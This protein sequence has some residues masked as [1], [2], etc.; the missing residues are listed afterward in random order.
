M[1][2][3]FPFAD[4]KKK[5]PAGPKESLER[6]L[7]IVMRLFDFGYVDYAAFSDRF[8]ANRRT[9][10]RDLK[11]IRSASHERLSVSQIKNGRAV[12]QGAAPRL[13]PLPTGRAR[14]KTAAL[15]RIAAELGGPLSDELRED[16]ARADD[17]FLDVREPKPAAPDCI[18]EVFA[19]LRD[20]AAGPAI[21]EFRYRKPEGSEQRRAEPYHVCVRSGRYYLTAYDLQK[22]GWRYFALDRIDLRGFRKAGTFTKRPIPPSRMAERAVGWISGPRE[23]AVTIAL[24]P[25]IADAVCSQL[26]QP[27]QIVRRNADGSAQITLTFADAGE[28]ARWSL[29]YAPEALVLAPPEAVE[30]ARETISAAADR[31]SEQRLPAK[32]VG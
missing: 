19:K 15:E 1:T 26:L 16:H 10:Q 18:S 8:G 29:R 6:A 21:V 11:A 25:V 31:Y 5:S 23:L 24:S 7:W 4:R 12:L 27:E 17:G 22:R 3:A 20:A 32:D 30:R 13:T 14:S 2:T 28:A 9:F